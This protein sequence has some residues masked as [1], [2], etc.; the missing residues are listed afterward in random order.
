[1]TE[2]QTTLSLT[3]PAGTAA[4]LLAYLADGCPSAAVLAL[5]AA[6]AKAE[7]KPKP[8]AEAK[9]KA[10]AKPKP[11][12][13][14]KAKPKAKAEAKPKA[15]AEAKAEAKP[16]A[17]PKAKAPEA[18]PPTR[19]VLTELAKSCM[20]AVGVEPTRDVFRQFKAARLSELDE[21]NYVPFAAALTNLMDEVTS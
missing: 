17:K 19:E 15:K 11:K 18:T 14:A 1:M 16:K 12:A 9:A 4:K 20:A 5:R 10:E 3:L 21:R 13:E 6:K 8:K 7:A 2:Q